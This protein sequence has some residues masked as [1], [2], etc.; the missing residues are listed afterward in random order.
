M[1]SLVLLAYIINAF[2]IPAA[3]KFFSKKVYGKLIDKST[4]LPISNADIGII[5][6]EYQN[7][8]PRDVKRP[9]D[10]LAK[11]DSFGCFVLSG[12]PTGELH[13][14]IYA[15]GYQYAT[16][17]L[18][19]SNSLLKTEAG[20]IELESDVRM[21][22]PIE[23]NSNEYKLTD[24]RQSA[25]LPPN[26][27]PR[28]TIKPP[29]K[30]ENC[31]HGTIDSIGGMWLFFQFYYEFPL[32]ITYMNPD[33]SMENY[34]PTEFTSSNL[35]NLIAQNNKLIICWNKNRDSY[36]KSDSLVCEFK[37]EDLRRDS[38]SDGLVDRFETYVGLDPNNSDSDGD[39]IDD[40]ND[41]FP[42]LA[43][44]TVY[45]DTTAVIES[46]FE[47]QD[48]DSHHLWL[49]GNTFDD[50]IKALPSKASSWVKGITANLDYILDKKFARK[51]GSFERVLYDLDAKSLSRMAQYLKSI[52][53]PP[54]KFPERS[55]FDFPYLE[56]MSHANDSNIV[57]VRE[58]ILDST[59]KLFLIP[60]AIA[61]DP[62]MFKAH[63]INTNL[64]L[65][66]KTLRFGHEHEDYREI[67]RKIGVTPPPQL[68]KMDSDSAIIKNY[69]C[70]YG[71][72]KINDRWTLIK[73]QMFEIY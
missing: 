52:K 10:I 48:Y 21:N 41:P 72:L 37:I 50:I 6:G 53:R 51:I 49:L 29:F 1:I 15:R 2:A 61:G 63:P 66:P 18:V 17:K 64:I 28:R 39:G 19:T 13:L 30:P 32:M 54:N 27:K 58:K 11:T 16:R 55:S 44:N 35:D 46:F 24:L 12:V 68:I 38:D 33:G 57:S 3:R 9:M 8:I 36:S 4:Q 67:K 70:E 62:V 56:A 42:T 20:T 5:Y 26:F 7:P 59:F 71:F 73:W 40:L 45:N 43:Q 23:Q 69:G 22:W 47:C 65:I 25:D 14:I 34:C 31:L 60:S